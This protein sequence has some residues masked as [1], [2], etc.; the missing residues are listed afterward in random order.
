[1]WFV[2]VGEISNWL[3]TSSCLRWMILKIQ[4]TE[5]SSIVRSHYSIPFFRHSCSR[6]LSMQDSKTLLISSLRKNIWLS[7]K[8][9]ASTLSGC[10][11]SWVTLISWARRLSLRFSTSSGG[12]VT[13]KFRTLLPYWPQMRR[14]HLTFIR[15]CIARKNFS[16]LHFSLW[17]R[18]IWSIW[19]ASN[20]TSLRLPPPISTIRATSKATSS[21]VLILFMSQTYT[22][23]SHPMSRFI[24]ITENWLPFVATIW[25]PPT[26]KDTWL[27]IFRK[28]ILAGRRE[29]E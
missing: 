27:D 10:F 6:C 17:T 2:S 4:T 16:D 3:T 24:N 12:R 9:V 23:T 1:M 25:T 13:I 28:K 8:E 15:S 11:N 5:S 19:F 7:V 29:W 14:Y 21:S 18:H 20:F 22:P 26:L